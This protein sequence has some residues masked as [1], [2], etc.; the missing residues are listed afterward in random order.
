MGLEKRPNRK[1]KMKKLL[2]SRGRGWRDRVCWRAGS[3]VP[4]MSRLIDVRLVLTEILYGCLLYNNCPSSDLLSTC[5]PTIM[6]SS[7]ARDKGQEFGPTICLLF[8]FNYFFLA[9]QLRRFIF[10][11]ILSFKISLFLLSRFLFFFLS[12]ESWKITF[13]FWNFFLVYF[14][15]SLWDFFFLFSFQMSFFIC[16]FSFLWNIFIFKFLCFIFF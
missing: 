8:L 5:Q 15:F 3:V 16:K 13:F 4:K 7:Q 1:R 14:L 9:V 6:G 10:S 12:C 11:F 2:L